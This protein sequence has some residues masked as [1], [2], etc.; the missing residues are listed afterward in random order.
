M[1]KD[2]NSF[3]FINHIWYLMIRRCYNMKD[4][5]Y[6]KYGGRG[7]IVC[8]R[9]RKS[10]TV[11]SQ[12][13]GKRLNFSYSLDRINNNGDYKPSNCRWATKSQQ[14]YNRVYKLTTEDVY[15][16]HSMAKKGWE[17]LKIANCFRVS[18]CHINRVLS[19]KRR[20]LSHI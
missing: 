17:Q 7:I 20:P 8:K 6:P 12:D 16:I 3:K 9:W 19:G 2:C 5:A 4:T 13:M 18:L 15:K 10:Y 14:A 11:F 1:E